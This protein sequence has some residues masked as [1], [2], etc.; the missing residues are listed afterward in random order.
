MSGKPVIH[1][2]V[3]S[4]VICP[5]CWVG[6][7]RL[8]TA[9]NQNK[10]KYDFVVRWEPFLLRPGTPE[11]GTPKP[12]GFP[13]ASALQRIQEAGKA[14]G[15]D[16]TLKSDR[17]PRTVLAHT[18]LEFAKETEGGNKQND[19]QEAIF[20]GFF[21]D[22][23]LPDEETL[24]MFAQAVGLDTEKART[25]IRDDAHQKETFNRAVNWSQRGVTGVPMFFM[26]GHA[27][28]SGA[29]DVDIFSQAFDHAVTK[30]ST[31]KSELPANM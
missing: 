9:I 23:L 5:W 30:N 16:F 29:Q 18:L 19:L 14:V 10:D 20:K 27:T 24:L 22:G 31:Q 21:T 17:I 7:R 26:N 15:I 13:S 6:K 12:P 4:D 28:F 11:D 25:F 3:V 8:E 2:D 1:I